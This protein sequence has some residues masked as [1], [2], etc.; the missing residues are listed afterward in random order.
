MREAA[1]VAVGR[2]D[3]LS[4]VEALVRVVRLTERSAQPSLAATT[5]LYHG[6]DLARRVRRLLAPPAP[7]PARSHPLAFDLAAIVFLIVAGAVILPALQIM[8]EVAARHLP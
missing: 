4:A 6:D 2:L 7:A 1:A 8:V 3:S 5:A